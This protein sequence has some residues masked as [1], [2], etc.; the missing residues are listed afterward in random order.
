MQFAAGSQRHDL[1]RYSIVPYVT[2][3]TVCTVMYLVTVLD[4][5]PHQYC[6]TCKSPGFNLLI[7]S[8]SL[9]G[10][11][12]VCLQLMTRLAC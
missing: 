6:V 8:F 9:A 11:M 1:G 12:S 3:V 4:R 7:H 2:M 10:V 5:P